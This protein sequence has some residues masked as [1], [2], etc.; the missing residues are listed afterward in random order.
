[1]RTLSHVQEMVQELGDIVARIGRS[2]L[3]LEVL[4]E[5]IDE[6][7]DLLGDTA[8]CDPNTIRARELIQHIQ[9]YVNGRNSSR[10]S[11]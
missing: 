11:R 10:R 6:K 2:Q 1:M 8:S 5:I 9:R 3:D 7:N 4:Q